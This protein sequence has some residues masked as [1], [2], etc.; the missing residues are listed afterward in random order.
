[1]FKDLSKTLTPVFKDFASAAQELLGCSKKGFESILSSS[2]SQLNEIKYAKIGLIIFAFST[3]FKHFFSIENRK[4]DTIKTI[5]ENSD[6]GGTVIEEKTTYCP[7]N[8]WENA[9]KC[10]MVCAG[11]LT[12]FNEF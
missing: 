3:A 4:I 11:G 6:G 9:S 7:A 8:N 5:T 10:M 12:L 2:V 1:M